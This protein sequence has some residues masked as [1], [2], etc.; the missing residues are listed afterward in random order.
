MKLIKEEARIAYLDEKDAL[1]GEV[2]FPIIDGVIQ[3]SH[4]FVDETYRGK[5]IAG[6]LLDE[7]VKE[8]RERHEKAI[9]VCTYSVSYFAKH[10]ES[11]DVVRR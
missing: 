3:I 7:V 10:P 5:G 8:L 1:I 11:L 4:T 9:P 2:D 6:L